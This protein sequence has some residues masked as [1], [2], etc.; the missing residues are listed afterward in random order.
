MA[1]LLLNNG[2]DPTLKNKVC[3]LLTQYLIFQRK[4]NLV[5][6]LLKVTV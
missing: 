2:A 4:V 3:S 5:E 6:I 1:L